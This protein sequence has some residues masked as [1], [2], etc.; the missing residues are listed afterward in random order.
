ML[1]SLL[2]ICALAFSA[3]AANF[4]MMELNS[5]AASGN[6]ISFELDTPVLLEGSDV[7]L[8]NPCIQFAGEALN[9]L[10]NLI[11]NKAVLGSCGKLCGALENATNSKPLGEVCNVLCDVVGIKDFIKWISN[12]DLSPI[13]EC[14]E[15]GVC[16]Y[17]DY[18][19]ATL[20]SWLASP[21]SGPAGTAIDLAFTYTS[22]N[23][24]GTGEIR[25]ALTT[26][27]HQQVS[28]NSIYIADT[29]TGGSYKGSG[30]VDTTPAAPGCDPTK[31]TC[32]MWLPGVYNASIE[33]CEGECGSKHPHSSIYAKGNTS[34]TITNGPPVPPGPSPPAPPAPPGAKQYE[35]PNDGP[36]SA[37][38][39]AIQITGVTGGFCSPAC[40]ASTACPPAPS[41]STAKP[42]CALEK[43]PSKTPSNCALICSPSGA[44]SCPTGATCKAISGTGICTYDK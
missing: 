29:T 24:T 4:T 8:C 28:F 43:P 30:S 10:I 16:K 15:L 12:A 39:D 5:A 19:D 21:S 44:N 34:F 7:D 25:I 41:G 32:E 40:S 23:G 42:T 36:C 11:L 35:D 1:K 13:Y 27:D 2:L 37:N 18:G 17:N 38:E 26:V 9:E 31:S 14:Q 33:I 6:P 22:K 20:T 3:N